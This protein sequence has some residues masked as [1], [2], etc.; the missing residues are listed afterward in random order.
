MRD[1][2][3][4]SQCIYNNNNPQTVVLLMLLLGKSHLALILFFVTVQLTFLP[5]LPRAVHA[6][7]L[8]SVCLIRKVT[9]VGL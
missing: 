9:V 4:N 2:H 3:S 5:V 1:I 8:R 7:R 6:V